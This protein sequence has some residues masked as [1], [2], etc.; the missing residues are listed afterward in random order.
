MLTDEERNEIRDIAAHAPVKSAAAIDVLKAVQRRRGHVSDEDLRDAAALLDMSP[1]QLDGVATFYSLIF[2]RPV[3]RHVSLVCD[4]ISC[5]VLRSKG[6][7][8]ALTSRLGI[9]PGETTADGRFTL[10]PAACLGACDHAPVIMIDADL[11]LDVSSE[12]L[13]G[14]LDTYK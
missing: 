2:R 8:E 13:V 4:S 10:L 5:W 11:H 1:D 9:Q 12:K 3:G 6:L 14:I 7:Y